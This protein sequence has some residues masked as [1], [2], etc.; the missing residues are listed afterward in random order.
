MPLRHSPLACRAVALPALFGL[1]LLLTACGGGNGGA[2]ALPP[3]AT[4]PPP[5]GV[6]PDG[7]AP[8]PDPPT[9]PLATCGALAGTVIAPARIG[10]P[11]QG[12][13]ITSATAVGAG[14]AGNTL[15]DYCRVRG[16]IASIDA[17]APVIQFAVNLPQQWNRKAIHFGGGGFNGRLID[18]TEPIRFGPIDKP[19]PLALGYVTFGD[20]GGHQ[21]GSIT[22]AQFATNDEALANY[23]GQALKKTH[24]VALQLV[25][26]LYGRAPAHAYFLGTSTGGRDALAH[27]Q[28]W[29]ADYDGVI[30]NEPA[31]NYAGTRLSNLA[32]GRALYANG[33][34]GW[35]NVAKTL[36]VQR[37]V[38][39]ACDK[40]DGA[41]DGIVSNVESCRQLNTQ[42]LDTLRCSGG[43]DTG[44]SCLSNA[45]LASIRA[46]ESPLDFSTYALANGTTRAG[47]YNIL[48][49]ALV[50]GPFTTR[51]LGTRRTPGNPATSADANMYVTGDQW[52]KFFVT[53]NA[54]FDSLT[55]DPLDPGPFTARVVEASAITDAT[56]P[57]LRPFLSRGGRLILLHGLA[58]EVISPNST[59]DYY[60]RVVATVGQTAVDQGVRFYTVPGMGHGTG[61]FIPN[62]DSLAALENWVEGGLAPATGVAVDAVPATYG[63]TRPLCQFPAWP[64]YKGSGSLDAA[65]NYSCVNETVDP[66][67]CPNLPAVATVYKGGDFLGEELR[68]SLDPATLHYTLTLDASLQRP[69]GTQRTGTLLPL[70]ACSYGSAENGAT[71]V[72]GAGGVVQGGIAATSGN[73]F[74]PLIAFQNTFENSASPAVFNPVAN[75]FN[76]AGVQYGAGGAASAYAGST[77]VRNAG[78][79]QACQDPV[80]GGFM[81]Y[82]AD[83]TSTTKGYLVYNA[84]RNAFDLMST[85]P[86]G[87]ATTTGGTLGGSV[88]FGKVGATTVP[89][90]LLRE[91]ATRFGLRLQA[92]QQGVVPGAADGRYLMAGSDGTTHETTLSGSSVN[93]GGANGTLVADSQVLG[94]LQASGTRAGHFIHSAGVLGFVAQG[95]TG[96]AF[97]FGVR[98]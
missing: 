83:C 8:Q 55:L 66:L 52:A 23:G 89:L 90:F 74:V 92:V 79:F 49:G 6:D 59:I 33:G 88:I 4:P 7:P 96:A 1:A 65:V 39:A 27:I 14:D 24:D 36:L 85:S 63:R 84:G 15:G 35:L 19:A 41:A 98:N 43:A 42:I 10:L 2:A 76:T 81:T 18:G 37:T 44:D 26:A 82:D 30:A 5:T 68:L 32:V 45:Q 95:S 38:L 12:A 46:I 80:T 75:I 72:L 54:A 25:Q 62:W 60:R 13:T 91:S 73:S 17:Q 47:G 71:F 34:A 67:A 40:L 48:E 61:V 69:V 51:D 53:R 70:G 29:P 3:T 16:T 50:A 97:E 78:T 22:D 56:D 21:S 9:V 77:R 93:L 57:D 94:V 20:D 64:K 86:T 28:R 31:L 58:D 11:T 87:S